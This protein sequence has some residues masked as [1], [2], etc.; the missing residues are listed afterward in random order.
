[1]NREELV[2]QLK[3]LAL[4]AESPDLEPARRLLNYVAATVLT[5]AEKP[6]IEVL[7]LVTERATEILHD[8]DRK[9]G[10]P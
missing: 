10:R 4:Q 1:M 2:A 3:S 6:I 5:G 9:E 7:G 8:R